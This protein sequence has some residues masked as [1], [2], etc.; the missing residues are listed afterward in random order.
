MGLS[1]AKKSKWHFLYTDKFIY[2]R[3][4]NDKYIPYSLNS[5]KEISHITLTCLGY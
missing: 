3:L 2:E 5:V 1:D 4:F